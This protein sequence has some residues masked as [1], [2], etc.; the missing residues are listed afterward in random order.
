MTDMIEA[1][2]REAMADAC[3]Q[4]AI[5]VITHYGAGATSDLLQKA[6]ALLRTGTSP[7]VSDE[8]RNLETAAWHLD[9]ANKPA[10]AEQVRKAQA[11]LSVQAPTEWTD[12]QIDALH[13]EYH[14]LEIEYSQGSVS[15][16]REMMRDLLR[17]AALT[18]SGRGVPE[19]C[20]VVPINPTMRMLA[21]GQSAWVKDDLKRSTTLWVA[22]VEEGQRELRERALDELT[23]ES[24]RLGLY[25][26]APEPDRR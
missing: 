14:G 24:Q 7:V 26:A 9:Q 15:A 21:A 22:M 8:W 11:A 25:G 20:A 12:E 17:A 19:G 5:V 6:A 2:E 4:A 16:N 23:K 13:F 3:N 1:A 10:L 18:Q